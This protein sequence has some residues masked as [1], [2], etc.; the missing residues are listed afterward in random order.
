M[1]SDGEGP[2]KNIA[3]CGPFEREVRLEDLSRVVVI[4]SY[5]STDGGRSYIMC[6]LPTFLCTLRSCSCSRTSLEGLSLA[7]FSYALWILR[8][9]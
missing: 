4:D 9:F 1:A 6:S 2:A 8:G 3:I 5:P 7:F